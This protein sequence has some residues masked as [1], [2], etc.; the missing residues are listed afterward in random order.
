ME[1]LLVVAVAALGAVTLYLTA[2]P[3]VEP[4]RIRI[5]EKRRQRR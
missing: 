5:D 3:R 1:S 4:R 2:M